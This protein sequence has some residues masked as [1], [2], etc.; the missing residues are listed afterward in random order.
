LA[1]QVEEQAGLHGCSGTAT[2]HITSSEACM[3]HIL[4]LLRRRCFVQFPSLEEFN[5]H[6]SHCHGFCIVPGRCFHPKPV[7]HCGY[8]DS[9][10]KAQQKTGI[11]F[12]V[13]S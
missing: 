7:S 2:Q 3:V 5:A 12:F 9:I 11:V 8:A 13:A 6:R 1:P 10:W 4:Y